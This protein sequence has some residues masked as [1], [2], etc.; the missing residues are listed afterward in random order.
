ML[1]KLLAEREMKTGVV[2]KCL[3]HVSIAATQRL[4]G[5]CFLMMVGTV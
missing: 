1:T 3:D 4:R 2:V 5:Q